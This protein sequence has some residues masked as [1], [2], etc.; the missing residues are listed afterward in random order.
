MPSSSNNETVF[1]RI[2]FRS[3]EQ[4]GSLT[5]IELFGV[6]GKTL[7]TGQVDSSAQIKRFFDDL[8]A[9]VIFRRARLIP[10]C[11]FEYLKIWLYDTETKDAERG[12]QIPQIDE[13]D[14]EITSNVPSSKL[15]LIYVLDNQ[16][17]GTEY[18]SWEKIARELF[19]PLFLK[20]IAPP[21]LPSELANNPFVKLME[22][23]PFGKALEMV[24][25]TLDP[26]SPMK[27]KLFFNALIIQID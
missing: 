27:Q 20:L 16:L 9:R 17:T 26:Y 23:S 21:E 5:T 2:G 11:D 8:I 7:S 6:P 25:S 15:E 1:L 10:E 19:T 22:A 14:L 13:R 18:E 12:Y 24:N 3:P 4:D